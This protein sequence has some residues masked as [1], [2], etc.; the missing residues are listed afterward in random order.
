MK[1]TFVFGFKNKYCMKYHRI[2]LLMDISM[3]DVN[4]NLFEFKVKNIFI[5]TCFYSTLS[6]TY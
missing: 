6:E 2:S 4:M 5:R 3:I 1:R